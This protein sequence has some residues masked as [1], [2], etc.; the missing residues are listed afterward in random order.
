MEESVVWFFF[1]FQAEDGIRDADVTG[2]QTCA[3]PISPCIDRPWPTVTRSPGGPLLAGGV[4]ATATVSRRAETTAVV[5]RME[6]LI[7]GLVDREGTVFSVAGHYRRVNARPG[8]SS[9]ARRSGDG[10]GG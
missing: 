8:P 5:S 9:T 3:L 6:L 2:V 10:R 1:F 7:S 4:A